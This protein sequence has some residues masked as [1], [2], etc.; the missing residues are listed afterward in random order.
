MVITMTDKIETLLHSTIQHGP[1]N[2]RIYL[3]HLDERDAPDIVATLENLANANHYTKILT[4]TSASLSS[5]FTQHGY[6]EEARIPD[7]FKDGQALVFLSK[8]MA[9]ERSRERNPEQVRRIEA[10]INQPLEASNTNGRSQV[11]EVREC[12]PQDALELSRLFTQVFQTYPFPIFDPSYLIQ[13]MAEQ[14][15]YFCIRHEGRMIATA[16]AESDA[17]HPGVEMTDFA[18]S[19]VWRGQ[20]CA[21]ALLAQMET[22]M[23][24]RG[25]RVA[26]TIARTRSLGINA[27]FKRHGHRFAGVLTNNTN[28]A[29][30]IESMTV[31]FRKL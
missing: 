28:I 24:R 31:W 4:K 1:H 7:F 5:F 15:R 21:S 23:H 9:A 30:G 22:A 16:A 13:M 2:D 20:G 29:G 8:F 18:V 3:L 11:H 27:L 12:I 10:L 26:F 6:I 17:H 19:P 14:T 25:K